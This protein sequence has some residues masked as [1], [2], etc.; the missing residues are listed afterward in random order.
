M[1]A[2]CWTDV[3]RKLDIGHWTLDAGRWML[4]IGRGGWTLD[5]GVGGWSMDV[6]CWTLDWFE[7]VRKKRV[8]ERWREEKVSHFKSG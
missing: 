2:G 7:G 4:D 1:D 8:T 3:G 5:A 6:G